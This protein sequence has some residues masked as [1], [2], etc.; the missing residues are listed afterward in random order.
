MDNRDEIRHHIE[1]IDADIS[2]LVKEK[3][4]A[5]SQLNK[6][7][8]RERLRQIC[9][10]SIWENNIWKVIDIPENQCIGLE[11]TFT[12]E[13]KLFWNPFN[14]IEIIAVRTSGNK[15]IISVHFK[16]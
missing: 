7:G 6:P 1:M 5:L 11:I 9:R 3:Q 2:Q 12:T 10:R 8:Y 13:N 4:L 15:M 16:D 14:T